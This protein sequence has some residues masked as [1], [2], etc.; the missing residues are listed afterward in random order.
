MHLWRPEHKTHSIWKTIV[1]VFS[2]EG[3][4]Q[5]LPNSTASTV[6]TMPPNRPTTRVTFSASY[7]H[8]DLKRL[9]RSNT[10]FSS[11]SY[12]NRSQCLNSMHE[13]KIV[14]RFVTRKSDKKYMIDAYT[15]IHSPPPEMSISMK[16]QP[17]FFNDLLDMALTTPCEKRKASL[18][19]FRTS[20]YLVFCTINQES[21]GCKM[22]RRWSWRITLI[23]LPTFA[24]VWLR[25][26]TAAGVDSGIRATKT[27]D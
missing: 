22:T 4:D 17:S 19:M 13:R 26:W 6:A 25:V 27:P 21:C 5:D 16:I 2:Q 10:E 15:Y 18:V 1:V 9:I 20:F 24:P 7:I 8:E 12:P 11:P 23:E 3:R 14:I